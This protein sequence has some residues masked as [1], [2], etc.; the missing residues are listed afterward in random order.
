MSPRP[1]TPFF[2]A[3]AT[4]GIEGIVMVEARVPPDTIVG[5]PRS[6]AKHLLHDWRSREGTP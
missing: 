1:A 3:P 6:G 2:Q 4:V 5:P